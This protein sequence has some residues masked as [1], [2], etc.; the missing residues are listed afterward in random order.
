MNTEEKSKEPIVMC[1]HCREYIV[2]EKINCA[3]FRHGTFK[4]N[5]N[6]IPPHA[7]KQMCDVFVR[8]K[9]IYGCGKPFRI[10]HH[11]NCYIA[12]CCDYLKK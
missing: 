10:V 8:E 12:E 2:I 3:I 1:P 7:S 6:Q 5:G 9:L 11:D 4:H